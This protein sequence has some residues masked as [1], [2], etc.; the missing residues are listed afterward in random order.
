MPFDK[1]KL[2]FAKAALYQEYEPEGENR[3]LPFNHTTLQVEK[4]GDGEVVKLES[5]F[6]IRRVTR[7]DGWVIYEF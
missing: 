6:K 4:E 3:I 2:H 5:P 7:P 1:A